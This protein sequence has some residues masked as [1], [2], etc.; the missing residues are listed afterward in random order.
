METNPPPHIQTL[1]LIMQKYVSTTKVRGTEKLYL[2]HAE[3]AHD[4]SRR[5]IS[6]KN[7]R[8]AKPE[9]HSERTALQPIQH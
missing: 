9:D 7:K 5:R 8:I 4:V 3:D 1:H 6:Q 2:G